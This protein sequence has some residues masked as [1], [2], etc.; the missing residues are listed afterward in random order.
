MSGV[1]PWYLE[2]LVCPIGKSP[3]SLHHGEL[4]SREGRTY[5]VVD[6][7]PVMLVAEAEH[8]IGVAATSLRRARGEAMDQRAPELHLESLGINEREKRQLLELAGSGDA[9]IDPVVAC[10]VAATSGIAY[11]HMVG[12]LRAYPIPHLRLA[13][14]DGAELLDIGCNWGRWS[15]AAARKGYRVVGVDPSLGALM[16]ARRVSRQLGLAIRYVAADARYLPF[17]EGVFDTVFSYSVL[18]HF[19]KANA[20]KALLEIGRALKPGGTSLVQMPNRLGIRSLYHQ[21]RR[22]FREAR[23][24]EVRYWSLPELTRAFEATVGPSQITVDCF[25]GLGLQKSDQALMPPPLRF[26]ID[27]SE[28]LRSA[29]GRLK[30]LAYAADSVYVTSSRPA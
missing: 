23:D 26:A 9:P 16:A 27:V 7:V 8:T 1:D 11:R 24:F 6:G 2:N 28:M 19:S 21:M 20:M 14:S 30:P 12:R 15:I 17:R 10:L 3:L 5:P 22:R 4:V 25:F 18:Q 13:A 29:S